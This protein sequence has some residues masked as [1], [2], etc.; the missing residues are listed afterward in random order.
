MW[1]KILKCI[2]VSSDDDDSD[3]GIWVVSAA[4]GFFWAVFF[5]FFNLFMS[6]KGFDL[7]KGER[8]VVQLFVG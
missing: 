7:R 5:V 8:R 3:V 6:K 4:I 2:Q 1:S